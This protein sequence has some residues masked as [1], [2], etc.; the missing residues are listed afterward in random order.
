MAA[1]LSQV[2]ESQ[3]RGHRRRGTTLV[4]LLVVIGIGMILVGMVLYI[5]I[6]V[7]SE[8]RGWKK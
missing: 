3:V 6:R 5:F 2:A 8:L 1:E 4:E 7:M